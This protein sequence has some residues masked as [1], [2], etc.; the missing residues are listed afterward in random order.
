MFLKD[1]VFQEANRPGLVLHSLW[2]LHV[3]ASAIRAL[4]L[5]PPYTCEKC[6]LLG[7]AP[8]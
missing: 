6:R 4:W 7:E 3:A 1:K 8:P 2:D 5:W